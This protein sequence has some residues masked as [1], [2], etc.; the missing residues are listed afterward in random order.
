MTDLAAHIDACWE[1][2]KK[3]DIQMLSTII[4]QLDQ[5]KL[6]IASKENGHWKTHPWLKKA[7]LLF[8]K[9]TTSKRL[10][11]ENFPFYDKA[12]LK[13]AGWRSADFEKALFR[14]APG[15]V[16]RRGAFVGKSVV[17]MPC[18]VNIGAFIDNGTM[19]DTM[20]RVGSCAQVGK[21]CHIAA[22]VGIGGVLEPP[23]ANP[24]IIEDDCFIGAQSQIVE[25]AKIGKGAII[26]MGTLI[27]GSTKIID[28][29][30]GKVTFGEVP[31]GAVVVPGSYQ[32]TEKISLRCAVI[33]KKVDESARQ[34]TSINDLL[35]DQTANDS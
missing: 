9:Y 1:E 18:F 27:G 10:G 16:V 6:R 26:G 7:I 29:I 3:P 8:F 28:R 17:L 11:S 32:T 14:M 25:G 13:C 12:P 4:M 35:R 19:I 34:K 24:V 23:Q 2:K 20:A 15:A 5:G 30:T 22:G 31:E 33:I 21:N